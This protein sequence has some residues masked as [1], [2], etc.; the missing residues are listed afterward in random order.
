MSIYLVPYTIY[1]FRG[2]FVS[3]DVVTTVLECISLSH[4]SGIFVESRKKDWMTTGSNFIILIATLHIKQQMWL[5]ITLHIL[6]IFLMIRFF[7]RQ[8]NRKH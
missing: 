3:T 4:K 8:Q 2:S 6:I 7:I 1:R 5:M